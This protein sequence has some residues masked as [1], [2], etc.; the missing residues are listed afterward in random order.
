[1]S[2]IIVTD[3]DTKLITSHITKSLNGKT[4]ILTDYLTFYAFVVLNLK[5]RIKRLT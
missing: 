1:M 3:R 4:L 2:S 5:I